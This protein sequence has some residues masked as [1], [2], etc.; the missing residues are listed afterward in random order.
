METTI[1][2]PPGTGKTT[3]IKLLELGDTCDNCID[4]LPYKE[5]FRGYVSEPHFFEKVD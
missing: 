1:F 2:G 4:Q 3:Q 5:G